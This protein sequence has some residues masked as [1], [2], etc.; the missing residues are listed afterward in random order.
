M[1]EIERRQYNA[2]QPD[3][4]NT[5]DEIH[6]KHP[7]WT[8]DNIIMMMKI[9]INFEG[10]IENGQII[11]KT[12]VTRTLLQKVLDWLK[13]QGVSNDTITLLDNAIKEL[14]QMIKDGVKWISQKI[15]NFFDW[16]FS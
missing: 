15:S 16:L 5:Y 2:L 14:T 7:G 9:R 6:Q 11:D 8:H 4:K 12:D 3:E 13:E 10:A 1:T